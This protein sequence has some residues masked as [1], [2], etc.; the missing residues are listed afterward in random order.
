MKQNLFA[1]IDISIFLDN[2]GCEWTKLPI[3]EDY[4]PEERK[5]TVIVHWDVHRFEPGVGNLAERSPL[6]NTQ[7][8]ILR[9]D[10]ESGCGWLY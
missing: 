1:L 8:K 6:A 3:C 4:A 2:I 7:N 10:V 5:I 9:N